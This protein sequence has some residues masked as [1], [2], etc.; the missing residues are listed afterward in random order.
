MEK[1]YVSLEKKIC[2]ICGKEHETNSLLLDTRL[3]DSMEKYTV[4]GYDHCEDCQKKVD[5]NYIAM[6]EISN[7]PNKGYAT[8]KTEDANRT[9][10]I[11][12]VR[13]KAADQI[14]NLK[15]DTPMVF[16][17]PEVVKYLQELQL[18]EN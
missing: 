16:V 3:K 13:K 17:Q 1:S 15:I 5:D 6:I 14:F 11:V 12:W 8:M 18:K 4:T 2:I 9:G 7:D 10:T